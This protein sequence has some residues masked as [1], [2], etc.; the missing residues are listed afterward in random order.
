MALEVQKAAVQ[1]AN[2]LSVVGGA[3]SAAKVAGAAQLATDAL[4]NQ[5]LDENG[6]VKPVQLNNSAVLTSVVGAAAQAGNAPDV[7]A[8]AMAIGASL[9]S[10]NTVIASTQAGAD[11]LTALASVVSA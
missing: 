10:I 5:F 2:I 8:Q 7:G 9:G 1:V 11:G 4:V 3:L 6:T